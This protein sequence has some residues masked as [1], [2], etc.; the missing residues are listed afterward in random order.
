M[1]KNKLPNKK[2]SKE[3]I[4]QTKKTKKIKEGINLNLL[5]TFMSITISINIIMDKMILAIMIPLTHKNNLSSQKLDP[6]LLEKSSLKTE[7]KN[8]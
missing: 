3:T 4:Q 1:I 5:M 2:P 8:K 6:I 7:V